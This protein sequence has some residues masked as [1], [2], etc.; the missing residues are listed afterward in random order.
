MTLRF[1]QESLLARQLA[2]FRREILWVGV[3]SL[4]ANILTLTPT[5][6]M[7]QLYGRVMKSGSDLSLLMVT[8]FMVLFYLVMAFAEWLRSRLLVRLGVMMDENINDLV[9]TANFR[10]ALARNGHTPAEPFSDLTNLRQFLTSN[11]LIALFDTPWT[12]VYIAVIFL[13]SPFLGWLSVL[14]AAIQLALTFLTHWWSEKEV[15]HAADAS[16]ASIR[17][18]Q[19]KL[20]AAEPVHAMG[21]TAALRQRWSAMH[22]ES[23]EKNARSL[24]QQHRLQAFTKFVRYVMQSL[25][26]GAGG[27]MVIEGKLNAGSMIAANVLM[28]R[29]LQPLDLLV[30]T[31]K[32]FIQASAAFRRLDAL[33]EEYPPEE[34][35]EARVQEPIGELRVKSLTVNVEGRER[36]ILDNIDLTIP[37]GKVTVVIGPSGAGKSTL[38][39]SLVGIRPGRQGGCPD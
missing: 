35:K 11:G 34:P 2:S 16:A 24:E 23:L 22:E 13:L 37:S 10:A 3:F 8:L 25:T 32:P 19:A 31:W 9:F 4:F 38:A 20:R 18:A 27:L 1:L 33:L 39:R 21:M 12:P 29:A 5:I 26:L 14:F 7:L 30:S 15:E 17:F 28:S 36:P 6:Y